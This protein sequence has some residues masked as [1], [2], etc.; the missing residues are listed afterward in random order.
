MPVSLKAFSYF[1]VPELKL[2]MLVLH[3]IKLL[4]VTRHQQE[5]QEVSSRKESI[6]NISLHRS[7]SHPRCCSSL[8]RN[9]M[10]VIVITKCKAAGNGNK[11]CI[12]YLHIGKEYQGKHLFLVMFLKDSGQ[13]HSGCCSWSILERLCC[14]KWNRTFINVRN[15]T[16]VYLWFLVTDADRLWCSSEW[17]IRAWQFHWP[18]QNV[19]ALTVLKMGGRPHHHII[20]NKLSL[21]H[22]VRQ[23]VHG[24]GKIHETN[25]RAYSFYCTIPQRITSAT[26]PQETREPAGQDVD[27]GGM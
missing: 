22:P 12:L 23:P 9:D 27:T 26:W 6:L 5:E 25:F 15:Y 10:H 20:F 8:V 16:C 14:T 21:L 7:L 4:S 17:R 24:Y 13:T 2:F 1:T 3:C 19:F 18:Q 11:V